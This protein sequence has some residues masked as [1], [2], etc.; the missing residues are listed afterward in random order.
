MPPFTNA[1]NNIAQRNLKKYTAR[2][3]RTTK[4]KYMGKKYTPFLFINSTILLTLFKHLSMK[5]A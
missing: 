4:W 1:S 5:N 2:L 3:C